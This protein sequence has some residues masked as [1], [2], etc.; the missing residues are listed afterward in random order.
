[1]MN[2]KYP[3]ILIGTPIYEKKEYCRERFVENVKKIAAEYPNA[4]WMLVDNSR[5]SNYESKLSRLYPGHVVRV[6]R[7]ENSRDALAN[8]SNYL[9]RRV[10]NG[11]Y[12]YLLML[13]S[14]IFPP[15]QII[16]GLLR[17]GKPVVG[18]C[19]FIGNGVIERPCMFV[20]RKSNIPGV[21]GTELLPP[22]KYEEFR[23]KGL[24]QI[25]GM[26]VGCVLIHRSILERFSFWYSS[27]DDDRMKGTP[28]RKHPDVYFYL[29][30][31]NAQIPMF[32]DTD[33]WCPHEYSD[34]S[35]VTD[36]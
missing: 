27:A 24:K 7:G 1:M 32:A 15:E 14:D 21:L 3:S 33:I 35:T 4:N 25:H 17:H 16:W 26:G 19:Y 6:P 11:E 18:A 28:D 22:D 29:D 9:R 12:D 36:V 34:W 20:L 30:L 10:L 5:T 13:E 31:H 23:N 8:A 2:E